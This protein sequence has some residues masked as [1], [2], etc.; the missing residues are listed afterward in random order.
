MRQFLG[1]AHLVP[2]A[3]TVPLPA[4]PLLRR[5][6]RPSRRYGGLLVQVFAGNLIYGIGF[7]R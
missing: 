6:C 2:L 4:T 5:Q 1:K 3:L 7:L